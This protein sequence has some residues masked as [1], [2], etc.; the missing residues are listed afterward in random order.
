MGADYDGVG[1]TQ[2][3]WAADGTKQVTIA[4]AQTDF[5]QDTAKTYKITLD[6]DSGDVT[7]TIVG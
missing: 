1:W 2:M 3:Q 4:A 5:K 6:K 7:V